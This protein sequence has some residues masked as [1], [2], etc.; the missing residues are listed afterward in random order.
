M[1]RLFR[2]AR[3]PEEASLDLG[4]ETVAIA[5]RVVR[6]ARHYRLAFDPRR[7]AVLTFPGNG[8]WVEAEDFLRR[9]RDWL[10]TR[11]DRAAPQ[12]RFAEGAEIPLRG[13]AHRIV[14]TGALRG[15]VSIAERDGAAALLVPGGEHLARRLTDWLKAEAKRDLA[16]AVAR[17]AA[18]LGVR[19]GAISLRDQS[20]RWG[21]CSASGGLSFSWR[22]ILAPGFV[23]DY[24][25][26][27]EVAH[28]VEMNH[29]P[30][31]WRV[32][33]RALPDMERGRDWLHA[34]GRGLHAYGG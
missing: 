17:H 11:L 2:R 6:K 9:Q 31:Y 29:S 15:R 1:H 21:S 16:P 13:M 5:V 8:R 7:G 19:P 33:R 3:I 23:L 14:S 27:H 18:N 4:D 25:A 10:K 26:A 34:N 22:L 20:S 28:L 32:L 12:I 30:A 24:V